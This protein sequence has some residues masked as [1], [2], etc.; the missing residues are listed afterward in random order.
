MQIFH[1]SRLYILGLVHID[2]H[3]EWMYMH[4]RN[5]KDIKYSLLIV[6]N[7]MEVVSLSILPLS[8]ST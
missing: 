7:D 6:R 3:D 5:I 2:F 8:Q 1:V 4:A